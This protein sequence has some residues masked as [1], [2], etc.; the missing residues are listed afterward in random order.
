MQAD[1]ALDFLPI[2]LNTC[3]MR[4]PNSYRLLLAVAR[5]IYGELVPTQLFQAFLSST[6]QGIC[7][8]FQPPKKN[9]R[10]RNVFGAGNTTGD[11]EK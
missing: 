5:I 2:K 1:M 6:S 7:R 3:L 9:M 8:T 11:R 4:I 10:L